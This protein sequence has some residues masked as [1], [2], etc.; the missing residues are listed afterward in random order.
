MKNLL[1]TLIF[2]IAMNKLFSV[3]ISDG[4]GIEQL[5]FARSVNK[6]GYHGSYSF[7]VADVKEFNQDSI[8][9]RNQFDFTYG[10]TDGVDVDISIPFNQVNREPYNRYSGFGDVSIGVKY[11]FNSL[12]SSFNHSLY[13]NL[14]LPT[15]YADIDSS[16]IKR[17]F[18][19]EKKGYELGYLLDWGKDLF[20][21]H[22]NFSYFTKDNLVNDNL[23]DM[24]FNYG[25]GV[26]YRFFQFFDRNMFLKWN[27]NTTNWL[28][29]A[30]EYIDGSTYVGVSTD[31]YGGFNLE[32]GYSSEL[33]DKSD[34]RAHLTLSYSDFGSKR[35]SVVKPMDRYQPKIKVD[36]IQ[37]E[38][39]VSLKT[40]G[41][42][43][44]EIAL[45]LDLL[46]DVE[47]RVVDVDGINLFD[48]RV[49]SSEVLKTQNRDIVIQG[50]VKY[51]G[52]VK[53]SLLWIPYLIDMPRV[54]YK[55]AVDFI[56]VDVETGEVVYNNRIEH[57]EY[58]SNPTT[59]LRYEANSSLNR[60]SITDEK[61][62]IDKVKKDI[63][64]IVLKQIYS[65]VE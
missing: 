36:L 46:E 8:Q 34:G 59:Y 35:E 29:E 62:L 22:L 28:Y 24:G 58:I 43:T 42:I 31:L 1:I 2:L 4:V 15:G 20:S 65:K 40:S 11:N 56:A 37:F 45:M 55:I 49:K 26:K 9:F 38:D 47:Y 19:I 41:E 21:V 61:E 17:L 52:K 54:G 39:E 6:G 13:G 14:T 18:T 64:T 16:D 60:I 12:G 51:A 7:I 23:Y 25:I 63:S 30:P 5:K 33:Y 57:S 27:F 10:I 50:R 48:N 53:S 44:D 3:N 32:L